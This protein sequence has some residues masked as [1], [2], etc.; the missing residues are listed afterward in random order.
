MKNVDFL[1]KNV[2]FIIQQFF[3]QTPVGRVVNR[4]SSDMQAIDTGLTDQF[5]G[6]A[7]QL[8]TIIGVFAV[9]LVV[10]L[11]FLVL[12]P[13]LFMFYA[14]MQ[15]RYRNATREMKRLT[16]IT[17]SPIFS[18]FGETL[19]GLT[20]VRAYKATDQ[21]IT[22]SDDNVDNNMRFQLVMMTAGRWM[23]F[24]L[25]FSATMI[26]G[27]VALSVTLYP[28]SVDA[29]TT[30]LALTYAMMCTRTLGM[31]IRSFTELEL[32]MNSI[33]RVKYYIDIEHEAPF[34]KPDTDPG[35]QWPAT[36]AVSF[37][38]V[39]AR[40][41]PGLPLVV[42]G[43]SFDV[44]AGEKVGVVGRTGAGKSSL[45]MLLF[46][47]LELDSG[48]IEIG[49]VD[50]ATLGLRRLRQAIAML[51]QDPTLFIGSVRANLD[52]FGEV[53][54]REILEALRRAQMEDVVK[55]LPNGLDSEVG[56]G[57]SAFSVGQ[58][59]LLCLARAVL[60]NSQ[61]LVMDECT[62]SVDVQTD[63]KIQTMIREVFVDRTIFAI[64]H[65]LATIIDYDKIVLLDQGEILETGHPA[66]LLRLP[67]GS[68][69]A[70]V[71]Q[72]GPSMAAH[73]RATAEGAFS[74][75]LG[76]LIPLSP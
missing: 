18:H 55:A 75:G 26:V 43:L 28:D 24:Q 71:D 70:L 52:P 15:R 50:I 19:A 4:F 62:A 65:R 36:A 47:I 35:L 69:S 27:I 42:K 21:F 10:F 11:P 9:I 63:S 37:T 7:E 34:D 49:G 58:R 33:E 72:S 48:R 8:F 44:A 20:V 54:D 22:T 16:S 74:K 3:D 25:N 23:G 57:G 64:A 1:L 29:G 31:I 12:V 32:Q 53:D 61:L 60:R 46:R 66:E 45:M 38:D 6:F 13:P 30:G 41:R 67:N 56:E 40:Y 76:S 73:L 39:S 68:L 59:Q 17:K 5:I 14:G 2:D 51:P